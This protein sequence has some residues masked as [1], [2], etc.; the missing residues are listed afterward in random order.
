MG[1]DLDFDP[2]PIESSYS[3]GFVRVVVTSFGFLHGRPPEEAHIVVDVR[4]ALRN[5]HQD[6]AM[7]ELTGLDPRVRE[8]VLATPQAVDMVLDTAALVTSLLPGHDRRSLLV[9][10]AFG[11]AGGR[12]RSV[13]LANELTNVLV[14]AGIGAVVSHRDILRP[15]VRRPEGGA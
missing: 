2:G 9:Q 15:V 4:Q 14:K 6:P 5:P 3:G 12:H 8:H 10:V 11:C 13:V 7:R 1:T